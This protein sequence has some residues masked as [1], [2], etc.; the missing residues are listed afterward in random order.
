MKNW[1]INPQTG[2]YIM[3]G[4]AP[5]ETPSLQIP[6]YIRLKVKRNNWLYAP[7]SDYG[8]DFFL[9]KKKQAGLDASTIETVAERAL[10]PI[11]EDGRANSITVET[12]DTSRSGIEMKTTIVD[13][14]GEPEEIVF[15]TLGV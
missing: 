1:S 2:D 6:A 4:G 12:Q 9:L 13:A 3:Q 7:N 8:S 15:K 10:Q 11:V 14:K 5:I